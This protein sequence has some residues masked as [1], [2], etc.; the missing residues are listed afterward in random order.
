MDVK[1]DQDTLTTLI[2]ESILS[3]LTDEQRDKMITDA[4]QRLI[5]PPEYNPMDRNAE[6]RSPIQVAFDRAVVFQMEEHVRK[7]VADENS[8]LMQKLTPVLAEALERALTDE[9]LKEKMV[10]QL[11]KAIVGVLAPRGY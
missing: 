1:L 4:I 9:D 5:V 11:T 3:K 10:N 8:N 6:R 7:M 2:G